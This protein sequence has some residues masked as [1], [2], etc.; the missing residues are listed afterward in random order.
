[1][2]GTGLYPPPNGYRVDDTEGE[3]ESDYGNGTCGISERKRAD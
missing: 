3:E 1:M 2:M